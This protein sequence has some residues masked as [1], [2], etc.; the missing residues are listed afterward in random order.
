MF[1]WTSHGTELARFRRQPI[2]RAA[3][4]VMLL[5]P[6]L[7]GAMYVWAFWD[8]TT[9]MN[10]LPVALVN[11][12]VPN[13]DGD[14]TVQHYGQDVVDELVDGDEIGWH[15]VDAATA[16]AGV[17]AGTYYFSV[18]IPADFSARINSLGGDDPSAASINV[19]YDDTN[20]FLASTLG[21]SAMLQVQTA[22]REKV[23]QTAVD[24]LLVGVGDA[25]DGFN[26]AS[27]GAFTLRD[28]LTDAGNGA[29]RLNVGAQQLAEGA[30]KLAGGSSSLAAG[31]AEAAAGTQP[32]ADGVGQLDSGAAQLATGLDA[33]NTSM[34]AL[35]GGLT[36]LQQGTKTAG[37]GADQLSDGTATYLAGVQKA[38]SGAQSLAAGA[39]N[40]TALQQG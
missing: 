25:R 21:K 33:L 8:P 12:D 40:L 31:A 18:T 9:H 23:S 15:Q 11:R 32:L 27:D 7:Y 3:V 13:A 17:N 1:A 24:T 30:A 36:Q 38:G 19:T 20:S 22:V 4:A 5:I 14:G 29:D 16:A 10:E 34:P 26:T 35:T 2:T 37:V 39:A 28:G 6:L